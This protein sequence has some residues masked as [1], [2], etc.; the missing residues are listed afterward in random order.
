M[1]MIGRRRFAVIGGVLLGLALLA[2]GPV[3]SGSV[4][5]GQLSAAPAPAAQQLT[6]VELYSAQG[7]PLCPPAEAFLGELSQHADLL[8]LAFH[9]DYW[10][11][12][13]WPD[14]FADPG[15]SR[16]QQRYSDRLGLPYVYTPQIIIDGT[17][18][19]SGSRRD[20][21]DAEIDAARADAAGKVAVTLTRLSP[22][23]LR[24]EIAAMALGENADIVLVGFDAMHSTVIGAGENRGATLVNYNVVRDIK[25]IASWTGEAFDLTVPLATEHGSTDFCA[26]LVQQVG[27]G[28]ILGAARVD[29]RD[30]GKAT[31]GG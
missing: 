18:Q 31:A 3:S 10:D 16:R 28:R 17:L 12:L 26:V 20:A 30:A 7:C 22:T 15:F 14:R 9:V 5:A 13:G 6:V 24:I 8:P 21:V 23:Q 27:Q 2:A 29:M 25:A 19:A 4:S 1:L 11:Y